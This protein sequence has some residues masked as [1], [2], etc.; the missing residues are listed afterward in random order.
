MLSRFAPPAD[1]RPLR[2][3]KRIYLTDS[4]INDS[5]ANYLGKIIGYKGATQKRIQQLTGCS[6]SLRGK[7]ITSAHKDVAEDY[8]RPHVLI[9]ADTDD[10]IDQ[11]TEEI[12][13]ILNGEEDNPTNLEDGIIDITRGMFDKGYCENCD[14][15]SHR[16]WECPHAPNI[17]HTVKCSI[18]G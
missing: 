7:G 11:A 17:K 8:E 12:K 16:T 15:T 2:K 6:I 10:Q 14:E 5:S 3:I 13:K 18:C 1:Y 9:T 4:A